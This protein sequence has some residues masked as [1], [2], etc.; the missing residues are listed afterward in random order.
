MF[1]R[2][3]SIFEVDKR[4]VPGKALFDRCG[5]G[6]DFALLMVEKLLVLA[7]I[8]VF[9]RWGYKLFVVCDL[10]SILKAKE[11]LRVCHEYWIGALVFA[12]LLFYRIVILKIIELEQLWNAKFR[13]STPKPFSFLQGVEVTEG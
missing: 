9:T 12:P 10:E 8:A 3:M 6:L 4:K 5:G 11:F 7:A 13:P 2:L 1:K